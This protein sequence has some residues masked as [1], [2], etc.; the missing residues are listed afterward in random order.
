MNVLIVGSGGR[1]SALAW[2]AAKSHRVDNVYVVPGNGG[3]LRYGENILIDPVYPYTD[4]IHFVEDAEVD[5]TIVGPEAPLV[6]GIVDTFRRFGYPVLGPS[7]NASRLEGSKAFMKEFMAR[8]SIPTARFKIFDKPDEAIEF[9]YKEN[10][11]FVVKTDGLAA[12]KGAIVAKNIED[13]VVAIRRMLVSREFGEA[14]DR[15]I[16]EDFLEGEEVSV[17]II[18]DGINY[19]W[20]AS[21]QDHKRIYDNDEGPNTG[22]MGAYAPAP[23]LNDDLK[24]VI[25]NN[26]IKPTIN[27]MRSEGYPYTGILYIGL[28]LTK[29]GP[30]VVEYNVRLGDP[31]AQVVL[32]LISTDFIEIA[33]AALSGKLDEL[34]VKYYDGYC[35]GVVMSSEGYPGAYKKGWEIGGN[36]NDEGGKFV[37][38][39]GTKILPD[40]RLVTDGGRVLCVSALGKTLVEAIDSAYD[41]AGEIHFNGAFYRRDIG[42]KGLKFLNKKKK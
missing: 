10:R 38:H 42:K 23:F 17:F 36:L 34:N 11:P 24:R 37:F 5:L 22:G 1:E 31:E 6:D 18:T 8:H 26:I 29:S 14:G 28:M 12:G 9:V 40:G 16:I 13:T 39:A 3:T 32:P 27:G 2:C 25:D 33:S 15:I 7:K 41:K 21:A 20:L 19:K 35:C 4:L 30:A